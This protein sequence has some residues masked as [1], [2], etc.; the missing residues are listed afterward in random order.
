MNSTQLQY[1]IATEPWEFEQIHTLN[2]RT[3]TEEIPQ[4]EVNQER[5][6][7]DRFNEE[8]TYIIGID[9]KKVVAMIAIRSTR[10]FSLDE[11]LDSLDRYLPPHAAKCEIRLLAVEQAYRDGFVFFRLAE[12]LIRYCLENGFDMAVIS[13][14]LRQQKL[15][16]HMGFVPFGP[17]TGA[18][19]AQFQPMYVTEALFQKKARAFQRI[20]RN[21]Q[22]PIS[23]LPGPVPMAEQVKKAMGGTACSHRAPAFLEQLD[24]LRT[25]LRNITQAA[26]VQ[27]LLGSGTLGN[28][29]V[30][31]QLRNLDQN[32]L[33]LVS[34][35]FGARL[36]DHAR[37]AGLRFAT[38]EIPWGK[39]SIMSMYR[40]KQ[41]QVAL[42]GFGQSIRKHPQGCCRT[43]TS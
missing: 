4:H 2:Y 9:D 20:L 42:L 11:K 17:L 34:G 37:R 5:R 32:G 35:E 26:H 23:F 43:W 12:A 36:T 3:F 40:H 24:Q 10:P 39:P 16:K 1:K 19:A 6:R 13:G 33:I 14:V 7:I 29:A 30:A 21:G 41:K 25:K 31:A 27:I 38:V 15:Y 18:G 28:D 22:D 8:N